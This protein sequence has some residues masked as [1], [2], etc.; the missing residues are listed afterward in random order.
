VTRH[1]LDTTALVER[2]TGDP[3]ARQAVSDA[4]GE[5]KHASSTHVR[6]EWIRL[7]EGTTAEVLNAMADGEEDLGTIFAR[8]SQGWGRE[9]GQR[10]RIL[11][12]LAGGNRRV[13]TAELRLRARQVLRATSK[14]MF[15]HHLDEIRDGSE[16]GLARNRVQP[17]RGGRL[18][19]VD[20]CKRTDQIC[21]QDRFIEEQSAD[22]T[23]SSKGL[24]D[25]AERKTDRNMGQL[26]LEIADDPPLGKGKNCY[27]RTGDISI[28]IECAP[29]ETLLTT[30]RSF[31]AIAK[32]RGISVHRFKGTSPP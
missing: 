27:G 12:M 18:V 13:S 4:L 2:W 28:S 1:F 14:E 25:H 9:A 11:S 17:V 21:R 23:S 29:T 22:W 6:R 5:E 24:I 20:K 26:G 30:D 7:V 16:C 8:L 19:L 32:G 10:L 15:E 3:D 31:E